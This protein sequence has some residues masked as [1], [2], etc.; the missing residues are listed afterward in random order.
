MKPKIL[1]TQRV[2]EEVENYLASH[3]EIKKWEEKGAIP[4]NRLAI[5]LQG[6]EGLYTTAGQIEK[7]DE[8]LLNQAPDLKVVSNVSVGYNNFDVEVMKEKGVIGTHTPNVLDET[9]ADLAFGLI[10]STARRIVELDRYMKAG[11]WTNDTAY[12]DLW[13]KD[14]SGATLGIIGMGRIGEAIAKRARF[15][16]D[17]NILYHNRSRKPHAE[18]KYEAKYCTLEALLEEA[19][20]VL[21][22]TPLTKE[23]YRLIGEKEFKLMKESAVFI[24]VS[25]G[26]TVDEQALIEALKNKEIYAAGLD[27]FEEEPPNPNNP[28]FTLPNV[29]TVPHIGSA[30]PETERKMSLCAAENLVA[31]LTGN[32]PKNPVWQ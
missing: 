27:V 32:Q 18:E 11:K 28:L 4:K 29:V 22:M 12:A 1:I 14:V 8:A 31:V 7:V 10:L 25:R 6:I 15:G 30:T 17:M 2:S 13:G 21:L 26:Q 3:C 20:Y 23:T 9:V 19:D 16:F 5:E 24:N